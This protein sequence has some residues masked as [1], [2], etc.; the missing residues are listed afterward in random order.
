MESNTQ[1]L[2]GRSGRGKLERL[3]LI[4]KYAFR[5]FILLSISAGV[6]IAMARLHSEQEHFSLVHWQIRELDVAGLDAM[7]ECVVVDAR[8]RQLYEKEHISGAILLSEESWDATLPTFLEQ[9]QPE[10]PIVIYCSGQ[11]CS[12]S[13]R[14]ALR[15][16]MDLSGARIYVLNGGFPAWQAY[17]HNRK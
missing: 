4:L 17:S 5:S 1:M 10:R 12:A 3:S 16:L 14:V 7:T 13:K 8:S 15:L 2:G 6:S 11:A 9:W